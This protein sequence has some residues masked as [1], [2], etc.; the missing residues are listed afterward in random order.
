MLTEAFRIIPG[1]TKTAS[2]ATEQFPCGDF[3]YLEIDVN[4]TSLRGTSLGFTYSRV[5]PFGNVFQVA[6]GG[7]SAAG[8]LL[9][10]IGPGL[11]IPIN[12]GLRGVFSWAL[13]GTA[14]T[15]TVVTGANSA[16]QN[17][18]STVGI[19]PGDTLQFVAAATTRTVVS[20][21]DSTHLVV[22]SAVNST[23]GETVNV[24]NTPAATF[25]VWGGGK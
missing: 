17:L 21:T 16:T 22:S 20:V 7:V 9:M 23:T 25:S 15:T 3:N 19:L 4:V 10:D 5:D 14:I 6:T 24:T 13:S 1:T 8:Q 11:N 18:T 2:G 12:A